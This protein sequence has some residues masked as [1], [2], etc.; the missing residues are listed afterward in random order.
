[1]ES[2]PPSTF[3]QNPYFFCENGKEF[4]WKEAAEEI[5]K[6]LNAAGKLKDPTPKVF[7]ES[8]Y[9]ELFVRSLPIPFPRFLHRYTILFT[10]FA[11]LHTTHIRS[12]SC[13]LTSAYKERS[14]E[15]SHRPELA[16][17]GG[18]TEEA[19][20]GGKGEGRVGELRGRRAA[21]DPAGGGSKLGGV[22]E[23]RSALMT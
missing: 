2:S 8:D 9:D 16:Q 7:A 23:E 6:A 1:M 12:W 4:S 3:L 10:S 18:Q 11:S 20:L 5:G 21:A 14:N 15:C 17:Q 22:H 13:L 19:R